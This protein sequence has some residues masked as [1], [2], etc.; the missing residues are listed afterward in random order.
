MEYISQV[1]RARAEGKKPDLLPKRTDMAPD[2]VAELIEAPT[3]AVIE[4]TREELKDYADRI[5]SVGLHA[6]VDK[7]NAA[8]DAE[9]ANG[10]TETYGQFGAKNRKE[11]SGKGGK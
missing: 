1:E 7:I 10:E 9:A 5:E 6:T 3:E 11:K 8:I 2:E 4:R